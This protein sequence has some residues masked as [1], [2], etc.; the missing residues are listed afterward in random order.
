M[1]LLSEPPMSLERPIRWRSDT[2]NL[3]LIGVQLTSECMHLLFSFYLKYIS[4]RCMKS[5]GNIDN[6]KKEK[7]V[8][9][10]NR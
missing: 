5:K 1:F 6:N 2:E 8:N 7:T 4:F 9:S 10:K 3:G